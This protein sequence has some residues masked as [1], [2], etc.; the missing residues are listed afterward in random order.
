MWGYVYSGVLCGI[1]GCLVRVEA[2]AGPGLP[3]FEMVGFLASE[4]REAKERVRA[5]LRNAGIR[6]PA[7]RITVNLSPANVRKSGN[8]FD[9]PVAA[10]VLSS[11]GFCSQE[12]LNGVMM[13]GELGLDGGVRPVAG[14]LPLVWAARNAG[15]CR[16]VVPE[17]NAA[18]AGLLEGIR[19][20]GVRSLKELLSMLEGGWPALPEDA[21]KAIVQTE[22]RRP[23]SPDFSDVN[24]QLL[25]R[26]ATEI[27]A[28]GMHNILYI[29]P[30]GAGKSMTARRIPGILP[31]LSREE[32]LE[33]TRIYSAAGLLSEKSPLMNS[34]PFRAPHYSLTRQAM[35]GGGRIPKP[36][37]ISLAHRGVLFLDELTE[38]RG[39]VLEAL[40][41]PMEDGK[42][43]ISRVHDCYCFPA[44]AMVAAS[45]NPCP[46]GFYP[47]RE[48]CS[49]RDEEVRHYLR[50]VSRPFLDRMDLCLEVR[51]P[52][53]H[54]MT[55]WKKNESSGEIRKRVE[56]CRQVQKRRYK[57]EIGI[58][59]NSQLDSRELAR[60]CSLEKEEKKLAEKLYEQMDLSARAYGKL[61]KVART[62]ADLEGEER[63]RSR[64]LCE[65]VSYR[66]AQS[67][68]WGGRI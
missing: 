7:M 58:L 34:R 17:A 6:L 25:M 19:V 35:T 28:A 49:C 46:C 37:E 54:E 40:R 52:E 44:R 60:F 27:A 9:L 45:M 53:F 30:P 39:E 21:E 23:E 20:T 13:A 14:I 4:V 32:S 56:R 5:A 29:G 55:A 26:R 68:V 42:V 18:E 51:K 48:K 3:Y 8:Y 10:A 65:A 22:E 50:R 2:D 33:I 1:D 64:H 57:D 61:L 36:G 24:G 41:Q 63:I 31:A 66:L 47:D 43:V 62:I 15:V 38:F 12:R 67:S 11:L 16:C 59:F